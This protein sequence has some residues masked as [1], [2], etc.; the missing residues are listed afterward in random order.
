[1]FAT[2]FLFIILSKG[3]NLSLVSLLAALKSLIMF[4][5]FLESSLVKF[6][7]NFVPSIFR[8]NTFSSAKSVKILPEPKGLKSALESTN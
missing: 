7:V 1:M 8:T 4:A 5:I 3:S 2:I 6:L